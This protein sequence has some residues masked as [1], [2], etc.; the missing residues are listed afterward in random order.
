MIILPYST[1]LTLSKPPVITYATAVVCVLVFFSQLGSGMTESLMYYPHSWNPVT[2][3]T[4]SV[5]H[6]GWLH[7]I[8]NLIFLLAFAP[9]IEI[10]VGSKLR[11]L[12]FML[13]ISFIVGIS[14]SIS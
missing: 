1:A 8:G 7:L 4:A 9:A 13:L 2:M 12:W 14:F 6:G 10:L 3:I 5:A 11:Y